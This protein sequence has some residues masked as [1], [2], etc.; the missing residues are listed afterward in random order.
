MTQKAKENIKGIV[1]FIIVLLGFYI[2]LTL[3]ASCS[4][5]RK[6]EITGKAIVITIDT[7]TIHHQGNLEL[8]TNN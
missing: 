1:F 4:I 3:T 8:K 5:H 7:T 6:A 2:V